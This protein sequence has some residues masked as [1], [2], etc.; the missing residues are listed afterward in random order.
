MSQGG[1]RGGWGRV[2]QGR[3]TRQA[4]N[5]PPLRRVTA[6]AFRTSRPCPVESSE[7]VR[8]VTSQPLRRAPTSGSGS[9]NEGVALGVI[10][11]VGWIARGSLL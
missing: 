10:E 8:H 9:G 6:N 3:G 2:R 11:C 5:Q 1:F 4:L 7:V